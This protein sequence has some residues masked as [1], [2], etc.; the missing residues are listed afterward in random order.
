M[1]LF[2]LNAYARF[3]LNYFVRNVDNVLVGWCFGTLW[4]GFYK[5]SYD[6]FALSAGQLTAP[7][8]NISVAALSR[9]NPRSSQY[10]Q[11]LL[12]AISISSLVGMWL[13]VELT[14]VAKDLIRLLLGPAWE[15]AG[16]IFAFFGPGVGAMII[17]YIHGWIHLSIGEAGRWFRWGWVE[18]VVTSLLFAMAL[19]WGPVG[20]AA[21]WSASF[22]I[23]AIPALWYAGRP[24]QLG[25]PPML[26]VIWKFVAAA[27]IA[28]T[29]TA[30]TWPQ[31][32]FGLLA[33]TSAQGALARIVA[34]TI[35][36]GCVY[37]ASV[38]ALHRGC[39]PLYRVGRLF[40][41]MIWLGKPSDSPP[42]EVATV[43]AHVP[44]ATQ[45]G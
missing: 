3:T 27:G 22:W 8:T 44:T 23:L 14:F 2:G 7:L 36:V 4:L 13:T 12:T 43:C 21:A 42:A 11:H 29:V 35:V 24:I 40:R 1:V 26:A 25:I 5:R 16:R 32:N 17:Y 41:E 20:V 9:L 31:M 10:R 15:P 6:L 33:S 37:F 39:A 34:I 28:A 45:H 19:P 30:I 38:V 18:L